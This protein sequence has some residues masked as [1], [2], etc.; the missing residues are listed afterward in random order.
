MG[1]PAD[2]EV[3]TVAA[4]PRLP[5]RRTPVRA[6]LV[7][8]TVAALMVSG[9]AGYTVQAGD[10]LW[11]IAAEHG[12]SVASLISSNGLRNPNVIHPGQE[13]NV[14]GSGGASASSGSSGRVHVVAPGETL[15]G[16]S[17]RY[18]VTMRRIAAASGFRDL[19]WVYAGQRLTIPGGGAA[20]SAA[21][22][23]AAAPASAPAGSAEVEQLLTE[24]AQQYGFTPAFVKAVAQM[25]SGWNQ[26]ARSSV[27]AVGVM[28]VMPETGEW[29]GTYLVGRQLDITQAQDNVTAGVAFLSYLW[30]LTGGDVRRTLAGYYQGLQSVSDNGMY[31]STRHYIRTVLALRDRY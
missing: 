20:P 27:G 24:T 2:L 19:D 4:S 16:I 17:I 28:Q 1:F 9:S 29:V 26:S 11:G 7:L 31:P 30:R 25:E 6:L 23:A 18:G 3:P 15:M 21:P 10:T 5:R 14:S 8:L 13:L 22:T 12:I